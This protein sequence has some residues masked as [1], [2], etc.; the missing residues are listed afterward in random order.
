MDINHFIQQLVILA[1]PFLFALTFHELAHGYVAWNLGDPT[2]K[3]AGRLTMNPL[4]HLDPLGV[5]AFIIMK[6]GWAKPVPVDPRYFKDPQKG[7]LLVA[8]AGPAANV[9]TAV[10]SA[11]LVKF[12]I[13]IPF[14]PMYL[15]KPV[16]GMLVASVWIN[17]MLAVFNGLPIPPLD[18]SRV[19]MGILPPEAALSYAKLEPFGFILLLI[20]FYAGIIGKVIMPI[21]NYTN[22]LLLG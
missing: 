17:I 10:A 6:I 22:T 12:L 11:I 3:N 9:L 15:L 5:I 4:K 2:A 1:P 18:G 21:I 20:L 13:T 8:L 16:V 19:L 14:I 7:M